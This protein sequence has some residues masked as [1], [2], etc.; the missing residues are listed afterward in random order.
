[1]KGSSQLTLP[2]GVTLGT[3][4]DALV[5]NVTVAPTQAQMEGETEGAEPAEDAE[6][7]DEG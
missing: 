4:P 1:M 3:D 7:D 2:D 6:S 5:V